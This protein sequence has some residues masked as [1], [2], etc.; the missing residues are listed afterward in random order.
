MARVKI[1]LPD[2]F[3]FLT[4]IP[5]RISDINYGGHLGNDAVLALLHEAR[6]QMLKQYGWSEMDIEGSSVIMSDV[7]VVYKAEAFYGEILKIEIAVI[8]MT[9]AG[10]DFIYRVTK[11]SSGMEVARAKTGIV[12]FDYAT[13]K[14]AGMPERFKK[15]FQTGS[16][17]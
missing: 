7:A 5:V 2:T 17:E 10:C 15:Q 12:F 1:G 8:E 13:R 14:I 4:E 6:V 16:T 9:R 3:Q 11:K